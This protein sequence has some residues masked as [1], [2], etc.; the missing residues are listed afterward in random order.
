[1][2][3]GKSEVAIDIGDPRGEYFCRLAKENP[4]KTFV[5]LDPAVKKIEEAPS[6]LHFLRWRTDVNLSL[7]FSPD[8][9][10]EAYIHF[11]FGGITLRD[12][13][14]S[15]SLEDSCRY[16]QKLLRDL[17]VVLK[18]DARIHI[19]DMRANI[20]HIQ[21]LLE[22]EGYQ[23]VQEPKEMLDERRTAWSRLLFDVLRTLGKGAE[24]P[25]LPMEIEAQ[26]NG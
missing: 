9:I 22:K 21:I 25:M 6:N 18:G 19:A 1:M 10:D 3:E 24:D 13:P 4:E 12:Q 8:S 14:S 17:R 15:E 5:V 23:V 7:P 26:W 11:L 16:Y 2:D 20:F